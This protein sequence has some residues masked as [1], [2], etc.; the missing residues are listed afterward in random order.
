MRGLTGNPSIDCQ[1]LKK[2]PNLQVYR[3]RLTKAPKSKRRRWVRRRAPPPPP[4][5]PPPAYKCKADNILKWYCVK[6]ESGE[7]HCVDNPAQCTSFKVMW[8]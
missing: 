7:A 3:L 8:T 4:P 2:L 1:D 6:S 5:P